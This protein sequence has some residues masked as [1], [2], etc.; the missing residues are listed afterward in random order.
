MGGN[1]KTNSLA[2]SLGNRSKVTAFL[3]AGSGKSIPKKEPHVERIAFTIRLPK[4]LGHELMDAS[5][6]RRKSRKRPWTQQ[7]IV[8]ESL[9]VWLQSQT[10]E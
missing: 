6:Q 8:A 1:K 9:R 7:D 2:E 4:K 5:L 3:E 10:G